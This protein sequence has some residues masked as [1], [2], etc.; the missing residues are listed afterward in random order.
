M[1]P[2]PGGVDYIKLPSISMV[3]HY[4]TWEPLELPLGSHEVISL[5]AELLEWAVR[6][7]VPDLLV[8]DFLPAGPYGELLGALEALREWDGVAVAG[9]RD[10]IDEPAFVRELWQRTG[11]YDVLRSYY[12]AICVYGDPTMMEFTNEYGFD[13]E[14]AERTR[15]CGYLGLRPVVATDAPLYER[16]LVLAN[17][18]GVDSAAMMETFVAAAGALRRE[19][20]G[21]WLMV[22]GPL[23]DDADHNRLVR[24]GEAAGLTVRRV[25]PELRA[26]VALADCVVTRAGYNTCCDLLTFRRPAVL[27]PRDGPNRE[28]RIRAKQLRQWGFARVLEADELSPKLLAEEIDAALTG[29][30]PPQSPVSLDGLE[31]AVDAF[32]EALTTGRPVA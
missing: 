7:F 32:D 23:M 24:A 22:T 19:R 10:V 27:V 6:G 3:D 30:P 31:R 16:P 1:F 4:E 28:Q 25:I 21:T 2:I 26:H 12:Q 14:L 5:R 17:G 20:G 18:G 11:V 8:A 15:Y 13:A 29:E 9:F